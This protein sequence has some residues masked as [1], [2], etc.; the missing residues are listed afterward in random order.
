MVED[1]NRP[2]LGIQILSRAELAILSPRTPEQVSTPEAAMTELL[3]GL[4]GIPEVAGIGVFEYE[5]RSHIRMF[6]AC[7]SS[8]EAFWR[9]G[10]EGNKVSYAFDVAL[11]RFGRNIASSYTLLEGKSFEEAAIY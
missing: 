4:S 5:R 8:D 6:L 11:R 2:Q 9:A 3:R 10:Q 7:P 1:V